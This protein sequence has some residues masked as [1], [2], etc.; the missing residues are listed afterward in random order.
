MIIEL[1]FLARVFFATDWNENRFKKERECKKKCIPLHLYL[2]CKKHVNHVTEMN[3][4]TN[5]NEKKGNFRNE[6][7][8]NIDVLF[9]HFVFFFVWMKIDELL[10]AGVFGRGLDTNYLKAIH[11]SQKTN[12]NTRKA[13][14]YTDSRMK[15]NKSN[16][17]AKW[18]S[19][20]ETQFLL[21]VNIEKNRYTSIFQ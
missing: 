13:L 9:W 8:L 5:L 4:E 6:H 16:K 14:I 10:V 2:W 20:K 1:L 15:P 11:P 19:E 7:V 17:S 3:W 12:K 18:H 21:T